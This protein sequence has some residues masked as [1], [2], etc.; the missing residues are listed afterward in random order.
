MSN[1]GEL[2]KAKVAENEKERDIFKALCVG[3]IA[4]VLEK[5]VLTT[6]QHTKAQKIAFLT[7]KEMRLRGVFLSE[8]DIFNFAVNYL[9]ST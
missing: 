5:D 4:D 2:V 7:C 8:E 6:E 9:Q 1:L 3:F